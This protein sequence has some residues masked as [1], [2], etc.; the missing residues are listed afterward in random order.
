MGNSANC[1]FGLIYEFIMLKFSTITPFNMHDSLQKIM[2]VHP[3]ITPPKGSSL[4]NGQIKGNNAYI[5]GQALELA[6]FNL[7]CFYDGDITELDNPDGKVFMVLPNGTYKIKVQLD[8]E[9]NY[10][11]D[12]L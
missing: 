6:G 9:K 11:L 5:V 1:R 3:L 7:P 2:D 4:R 12:L 8:S 10:L